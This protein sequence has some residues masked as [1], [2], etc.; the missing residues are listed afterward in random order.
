[1]LRHYPS[2]C[3]F[4]PELPKKMSPEMT[5]ALQLLAVGMVS[6]FVV[7][8]LVV[9]T[10]QGLI[11]FVNRFFPPPPTSSQPDSAHVAVLAAAVEVATQGRGQIQRISS[12]SDDNN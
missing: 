12:L 6:V 5:D 11:R 4:W 8:T 3:Y 1:M 2:F 10:G 9:L 7:L